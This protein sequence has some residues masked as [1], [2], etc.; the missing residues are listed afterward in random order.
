MLRYRD[1]FWGFVSLTLLI[2]RVPDGRD[3]LKSGRRET[4]KAGYRVRSTSSDI[5]SFGVGIKYGS[6]PES[7]KKHIG[8]ATCTWCPD[9][10]KDPTPSSNHV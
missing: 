9:Q 1:P 2:S 3:Q 8:I 4:P 7:R 6:T 10:D 5:S